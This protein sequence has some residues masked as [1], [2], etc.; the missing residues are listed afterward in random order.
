MIG[1]AED[2]KALEESM[3]AIQKEYPKFA[4]GNKSAGV[5][6]RKHLMDMKIVASDFRRRITEARRPVAETAKY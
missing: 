5:R 3:E 2:L 4:A 1:T 6:I